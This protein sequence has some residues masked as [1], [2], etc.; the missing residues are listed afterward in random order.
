MPKPKAKRARI[1]V[2]GLPELMIAIKNEPDEVK[3]VLEGII[4]EATQIIQTEIE[5]RAPRDTG[6]LA[7]E[8]FTTKTGYKNKN[9]V[10]G[11]VTIT[12]PKFQ[13]AFYQEF[14]VPSHNQPAR[15]FIRPAF[16]KKRRAARAL[17]VKKLEEHYGRD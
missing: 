4:V 14:G 2:D 17:V 12:D 3:K 7:A 10:N 6:L 11:I 1:R 9:S 13:Y 5:A 16:D 15:P 8:G